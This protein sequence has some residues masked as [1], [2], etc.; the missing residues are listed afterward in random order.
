MPSVS[1]VWVLPLLL[2]GQSIFPSFLHSNN[3]NNNCGVMAEPVSSNNNDKEGETDETCENDEWHTFDRNDFYEHFNCR[4]YFSSERSVPEEDT[5]LMVR[6][7]YENAVGVENS[8]I[9]P[10][11]AQDGFLVGAKGGSSPGRGRGMFAT[12]FIPKG[13]LLYVNRQKGRFPTAM[14]YRKFLMGLPTGLACDYLI[15]VYLQTVGGDKTN[16]TVMTLLSAELDKGVLVNGGAFPSEEAH[17]DDVD[18]ANSGCTVNPFDVLEHGCDGVRYYA[19][20]DIQEGEE[21]FCYYGGWGEDVDSSIWS[22]YNLECD[23]C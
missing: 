4:E 17:Q 5:W 9:S 19:W 3:N 22:L 6:Q 23:V 8:S 7:V 14:S 18:V 20:S 13:T 15:Y 12:Q 2:I 16:T 11:S 1:A 10:I 21:F